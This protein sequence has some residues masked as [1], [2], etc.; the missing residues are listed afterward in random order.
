VTD[1]VPRSILHVDMDAFYASVE[2]RDRPALRG[3]PVIVGADP[4]GRGVVSAASYEARRFG[5]HSAMPIGRAAR[6]CPE[7][8]FL[9]V[10]MEKYSRVSGQIMA[11]LAEYSPLLE[12]IS[13]DEAF[14]DL[15]GSERLLGPALEVARGIK[16]R[17]RAE[18]GLT[19][20]AGLAPNKFL[21]KLASDLG[22]PDG[23]VQVR[24][25]EEEAFL[26]DLPVERLWGVGGVTARALRGMGIQTIGQLARVPPALL[27]ERF[28]RTGA[29]LGELARGRDDR[30]VEPFAPPK[31]MG[32]E[33]TFD[34]DTQDE[35]LLRRTLRAQAE[36]VAREL[37]AEGYAGRTVT[38]KVR[39][40]DFRTV[41]RR[42]TGEP[43]G[44]GLEIY[45]RA[46][47]LL[48]RVPS[49]RPIRLVGV[50]VSGLV[51]AEA[52]QLSLFGAAAARRD[53]VARAADRL[54]RRFG[55]RAL[56]PASLLDSRGPR[57]D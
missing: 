1:A 11:V 17:L 56:I 44:D 45:R 6:L 52:G 47:G 9:P 34:R 24:P 21:A 50:S 38:L 32:A 18:L 13:V 3:R 30:P 25:G 28:G 2:Q 27:A 16:E 23:L 8:V 5:V 19:A 4:R 29:L 53:R 46:A 40:S 54:A 31:S 14:L 49:D 10:D 36:R 41:T 22:K 43:T 7:A 55:E 15:T 12:P 51:R 20:S 57:A 48:E 33:E 39:F 42:L 35:G 37:R 26:Q